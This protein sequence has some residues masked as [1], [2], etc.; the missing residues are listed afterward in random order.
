LSDAKRGGT[1]F[2]A[3]IAP[4]LK[5]YLH[6]EGRIFLTGSIVSRKGAEVQSSTGFVFA[7]FAPLREA[8]LHL[9]WKV[10]CF[11]ELLLTLTVQQPRTTAYS[12]GID[13]IYFLHSMW[14]IPSTRKAV[15]EVCRRS[16]TCPIDAFSGNA[17]S[18]CRCHDGS[19]GASKHKL[20]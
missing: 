12:I 1:I 2:F 7:S 17:F 5:A 14:N 4:L 9:H 13:G 11:D 15:S 19:F 20:R 16:N 10:T 3:S 18:T 8:Y 6:W